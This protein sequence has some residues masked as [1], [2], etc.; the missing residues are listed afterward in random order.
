MTYLANH[1]KLGK[2]YRS[3]S[4]SPIS[5]ATKQSIPAPQSR[6]ACYRLLKNVIT[7]TKQPN[8]TSLT[9]TTSQ[10][11]S[12]SLASPAGCR[13]QG[14][15]RKAPRRRVPSGGRKVAVT[16]SPAFAVPSARRGL[17]SLFGMGRG[18]APVLWPP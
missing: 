2:P 10:T 5:T 18:G 1:F 13:G 4:S 17:T 7:N 8:P 3:R 16:Y 9:R 15:K 14:Q 12:T 11:S 6:L